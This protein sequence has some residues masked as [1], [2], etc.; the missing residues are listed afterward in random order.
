MT[1]EQRRFMSSYLPYITTFISSG[2]FIFTVF[3]YIDS[4]KQKEKNIRF[5]QFY[6][7]FELVAGKSSNGHRFTDTQQAVAIYQLSEFKEYDY[8]ILPILDFYLEMSKNESNEILFR[9][10][11]LETKSR[12]EKSI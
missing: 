1:D 11:L 5:E 9:K 2:A 3:K 7:I 4:Q 12:L 8:M 6:K 10:A